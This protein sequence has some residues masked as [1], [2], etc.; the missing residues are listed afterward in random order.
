M[1]TCS[2]LQKGPLHLQVLMPET[3]VE[4]HQPTRCFTSVEAMAANIPQCLQPLHFGAAN[5]LQQP[6]RASPGQDVTGTSLPWRGERRSRSRTFIT[7]G[8]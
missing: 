5:Y 3:L 7:G 1:E 4:A 2:F 6:R 8:S